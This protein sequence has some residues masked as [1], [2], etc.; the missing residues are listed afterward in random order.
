MLRLSNEQWE[1]IWEHFPEENIPA[2]RAGRKPIPTR[3]VLVEFLLD[4][5]ADPNLASNKGYTPL[6][7]AAGLGD[8]PRPQVVV[9]LRR[10]SRREGHLRKERCATCQREW[11]AGDGSDNQLDRLGLAVARAAVL[12]QVGE[13]RQFRYIKASHDSGSGRQRLAVNHG[14]S[15]TSVG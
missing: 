6:M 1:R 11:P 4:N 7:R 8:A 2:D 3:K 14:S 13:K 12:L 9:G 10:R 15:V 5:G